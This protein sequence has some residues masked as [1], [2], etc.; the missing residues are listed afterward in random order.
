MDKISYR[1]SHKYKEKGAEYEEYYQNKAWQKFLWSREQE[2]LIKI[3]EKYF[4]GKDVHLLDFACGTGRITEFLENHVKTSTGVDVSDSMLA[5][6]REKL[7]RTE[8]IETD[9][10]AENI[11]K[12]RK[13]NLITAFRFF[14]NA[15]PELRSATIRALKELLDED[16]YLVF[17]NHQNSGSPWIKIRHA[18]YRKKNPEGTFNVMS[19][20]QM[21]NLVEGAG[22]DIVEIYP[23]G[24][25]HPPKIPVSFYLNRAIDWAAGKFKFLNRFSESP[26]AVCRRK[27]NQ[28]ISDF[29]LPIADLKS[30]THGIAG[31]II[32][33]TGESGTLAIEAAK[34]SR[35][36]DIGKDCGLFYVPKIVNF[37]AE[38]GVLEFE[39][40]DGLVTLLDMA[41]LKD[42][43]LFE[44]LKKAG[45]ALAAIH[46]KL[47][48][49]EQMKHELPDEWMAC[50]GENVFIHGDFAGFN[51]CFDKTAGRLV[52][53][54]W[55]S[56]PLLGKVATYGSRFFDIIWFVIFIF[57]GAPRRCLFNWDAAAMADAFL[58]GYAEHCPEIIQR[59]SGDFRQLMRRYYHKT[60]WYL[61]K[62]RSWYKAAR[63]LLYQLLIYPRF[64]RYRPGRG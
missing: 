30:E 52:I 36:F 24:F 29:R 59:L 11:L 46:E 39:W 60:V 12:P 18:H 37:D 64:A 43:R 42:N 51:L 25:F 15:E 61:A 20:E 53:L 10:T 2:I 17:N 45:Q 7:K 55:N 32:R 22:F 44:L 54:D 27:R 19:I 16:G 23:A 9:I 6:A 21:K 26:I 35:A 3:L 63:Y 33:K 31:E 13:F 5:I 50:P 38:A 58:A 28:F 14:L 56:A 34:A 48:L 1:E 57:Y 8:V 40:L 4:A 62:Q 49:P 41:A 47:I